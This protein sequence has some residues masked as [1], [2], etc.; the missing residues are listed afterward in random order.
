MEKSEMISQAHSI[1]KGG[2]DLHIHALPSH[3]NRMWDDVEIAK[4]YDEC[5]FGGYITK[6]HY[7]N[8]VGRA[9]LGNMYSGAKTKLLGSV[10]LNWPVGGINPF[11]V[12]SCFKLGG[13]IVWLPTRDSENCLKYGDMKGDFFK[14]DPV[15]VSKDGKLVPAMYEVFE[16]TKKYDGWLATGHISPEESLLVCK[17]ARKMG[18]NMILTH[19]DWNR[20]VVPLDLQK[21]IASMGVLV[22]KVWGNVI[23]GDI[24]SEEMAHTIRVLGADSVFIVTDLGQKNWPRPI[25]GMSD[26]VCDLLGHGFSAED[27]RKMVVDNPKHIVR[28]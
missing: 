1:M 4:Q 19:P 3:F 7:D 14:R 21:E 8:T 15:I 26:F 28:E 12:E 16:A 10:T 2:F 23:K 22:E 18:V 25:D 6:S 13:K 20:T 17:E 27:I 11:A 9:L 24:T 5:E